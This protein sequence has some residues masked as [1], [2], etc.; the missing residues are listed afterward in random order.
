M[1]FTFS[2]RCYFFPSCRDSDWTLILPTICC[3]D[4][5]LKRACTLSLKR[6]T[7]AISGY[8]ARLTRPNS[9]F[10]LF[11]FSCFYLQFSL[12]GNRNRSSNGPLVW[13]FIPPL[14]TCLRAGR[15]FRET[16]RGKKR[17]ERKDE[18]IQKRTG[19]FSVEEIVSEYCYFL[20]Y[21]TISSFVG[22]AKFFKCKWEPHNRSNIQTILAPIWSEY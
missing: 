13:G 18:M 17:R 20:F 7:S 12:S 5:K 10:K 9:E 2:S 14:V 15:N 19:E 21:S 16:D 6:S 3:N 4:A 8:I 1:V 11:G 22:Y